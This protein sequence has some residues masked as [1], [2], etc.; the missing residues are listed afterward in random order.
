M[1]K[2]EKAIA[3][4]AKRRETME[5]RVS[6]YWT[7]IKKINKIISK[8]P[9]TTSMKFKS[10]KRLMDRQKNLQYIVSQKREQAN[11][12]QRWN[13]TYYSCFVKK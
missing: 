6:L 13:R 8:C 7:F 2:K 3:A 4:A 10:R 1:S 12:V 5:A 11:T 9:N